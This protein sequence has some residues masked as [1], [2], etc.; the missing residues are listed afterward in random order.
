MRLS[1]LNKLSHTQAFKRDSDLFVIRTVLHKLYTHQLCI[2]ED[3]RI[4]ASTYLISIDTIASNAHVGNLE[5]GIRLPCLPNFI[6][7][8]LLTVQTNA[9][10]IPLQTCGPVHGERIKCRRPLTIKVLAAAVAAAVV[11]ILELFVGVQ[12]VYLPC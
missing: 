1:I 2:F 12:P 5:A 6:F 10:G 9:I 11:T 7:A 3:S 4:A 8:V